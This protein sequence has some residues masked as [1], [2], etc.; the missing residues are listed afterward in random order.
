MNSTRPGRAVRRRD[1]IGTLHCGQAQTRTSHHHGLARVQ[2]PC[3]RVRGDNG[4][5]ESSKRNSARDRS[6]TPRAGARG[7]TAGCST[8]SDALL[9]GRHARFGQAFAVWRAQP[10]SASLPRLVVTASRRLVIRPV[11]RKAHVG[12]GHRRRH[13]A[14]GYAA[15][16]AQQVTVWS[17]PP[18]GKRPVRLLRGLRCSRRLGPAAGLASRRSSRY[19]RP[20]PGSSTPWARLERNACAR[21]QP[22]EGVAAPT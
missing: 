20:R 10:P 22:M 7:L 3:A 9:V 13:Q 12:G 16:G 18:P 5:A 14:A 6:E 21:K 11:G 2:P 19:M 1:G 17:P 15:E 8:T 4:A